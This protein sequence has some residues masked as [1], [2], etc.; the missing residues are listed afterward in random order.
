[1]IEFVCNLKCIILKLI[2]AITHQVT[3]F[4]LIVT[5]AQHEQP[6]GSFINDKGGETYFSLRKQLES[7][8]PLQACSQHSAW[9]LDLSSDHL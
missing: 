4:D 3:V 5:Q 6:P 2:N 7:T 8:C 9:E 1:M